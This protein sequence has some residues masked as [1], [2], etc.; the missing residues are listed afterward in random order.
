MADLSGGRRDQDGLSGLG[1][2][3][4]ND[5]EV[6]GKA[7]NTEDAETRGLGQ[8]GGV[9]G[10]LQLLWQIIHLKSSSTDCDKLNLVLWLG[11]W[12]ETFFNSVQKVLLTSFRYIYKG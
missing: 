3:Q 6:S 12:S 10:H 8:R 9:E 1:L 4:M 5:A 7:G 11:F 2:A